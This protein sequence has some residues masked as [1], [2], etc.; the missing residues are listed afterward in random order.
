VQPSK[1]E[2]RTEAVAWVANM[3]GLLDTL[4]L[5]V[6]FESMPQM[7]P[8]PAVEAHPSDRSVVVAFPQ[9]VPTEEEHRKAPKV[10]G[11]LHIDQ[12][13]VRI[14]H[15]NRMFLMVEADHHNLLVVVLQMHHNHSE[16]KQV[17]ER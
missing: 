12:G 3:L 10:A 11:E 6:P 2:L 4:R 7:V 8:H 17:V 16:Q 1:A 15:R 9:K 5:A 14:P 13:E